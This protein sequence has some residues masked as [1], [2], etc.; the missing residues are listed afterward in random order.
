MQRAGQWLEAV[1][2]PNNSQH[3][4]GLREV[5][6]PEGEVD[7]ARLLLFTDNGLRH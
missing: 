2:F 6:H 3:S 5:F 4:S 7:N 1:D